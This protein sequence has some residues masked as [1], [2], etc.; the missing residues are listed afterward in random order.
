MLRY[1]NLRW[2]SGA[3]CR[4]VYLLLFAEAVS[5]CICITWRVPADDWENGGCDV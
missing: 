4:T 5:C 1:V 2:Y 3:H